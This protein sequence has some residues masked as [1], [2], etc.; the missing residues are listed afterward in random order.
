VGLHADA[1]D[2]GA[3]SFDELDNVLG[4]GGFCTRGFDVVVVVKE[5]ST[6]VCGSSGG[7]GDGDVCWSDGVVE[8]VGA[9][10]TVLVESLK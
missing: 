6:G 10:G 4:T 9:V 5:L 7:E 1:I 2:F 8:D 3:V